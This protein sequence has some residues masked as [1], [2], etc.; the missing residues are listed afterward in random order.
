MWK[1]PQNS[2]ERAELLER[3]LAR[4]R[5]ECKLETYSE[6]KHQLV[7]LKVGLLTENG[8]K[9]LFRPFVGLSRL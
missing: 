7:L 2:K 6:K 9:P 3:R 1:G 8:T 5:A 4:L